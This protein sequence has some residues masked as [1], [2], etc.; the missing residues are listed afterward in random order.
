MGSIVDEYV[1]H[2]QEV[3]PQIEKAGRERDA[4]ALRKLTHKLRGTGASYGF[5][6]VTD[7]AAACEDAVVS[8]VGWDEIDPLG[9]Q[10]VDV[11]RRCVAR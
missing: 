6:E 1:D 4:I 10:M 9:R 5:Q 8:G 2:I 11:L 7:V 3:I